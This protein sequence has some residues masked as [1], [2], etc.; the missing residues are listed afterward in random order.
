MTRTVTVGYVPAHL[1][2]YETSRHD[3][4]GR[5]REVLARRVGAAGGRLASEVEPVETKAQASQAARRMAAEGADLVVLQSASFAMG[6]VVEPFADQGH[7]ICLWAPDEPRRH[8]PI[9]LNGFVSMHL[10]AGV[11]RR[12]ARERGIPFKWLFG[13]EGH[14]W[15]EDRLAVTLRAVRGLAS[16]EGAR[17]GLVGGVAPSFLNVVADPRVLHDVLDVEV[18]S[19]ELG[20]VIDT[21]ESILA[22]DDPSALDGVVADLRDAARGRVDVD[23]GDLRRNAAVYAALRRLADA[24]ELDALAVSD[25]PVF[26]ER[27]ELHPGLAFSWLDEHDGVPVASEGDVGGALSMLLARGVAGEP[28]MLLD[29]NDVDLE[30]DALLTWHCGGSP[31]AIA[32]ERGVRWTPHTTLARPPASPMGTVADL[33]FRHGPVTLLRVSA[34]GARLFVVDAAV[35]PTPHP[36]FDGSRGWVSEFRDPNGAIGAGDVVQTL[37]HE[38]IEHHLALVPGHHAASLRE[39]A[40]WLGSRPITIHPYRDELLAAPEIRP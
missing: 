19:F 32:D 10:H 13:D 5:S 23:D 28:A 27:M 40:A 34:D 37:M 21:A 9:P 8:G 6:D 20:D 15:F 39:A 2:S 36:G 18:A 16:L 14:P 35:V 25:W 31:L 3:V 1:P 33:Q 24:H 17:V 11:L 7:R 22:S 29:V 4:I 38:G 26:Q 12:W 30:H